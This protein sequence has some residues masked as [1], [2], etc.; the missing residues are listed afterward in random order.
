MEDDAEPQA[1]AAT[2]VVSSPL[3]RT[4]TVVLDDQHSRTYRLVLPEA[5]MCEAVRK[6]CPL[7]LMP[8][9]EPSSTPSD[10]SKKIEL[11]DQPV[12]INPFP[13][14]FDCSH[15]TPGCRKVSK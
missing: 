5:E 2:S 7:L 14:V 1:E 8:A 4:D 3:N 15:Y 10:A 12:L 13:H 6:A 9:I 11:R